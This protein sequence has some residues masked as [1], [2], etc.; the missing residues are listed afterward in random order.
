MRRMWTNVWGTILWLKT[1][2]FETTF[3]I[4]RFVCVKGLERTEE[5]EIAV[6]RDQIQSATHQTCIVVRC[7]QLSRMRNRRECPS[8]CVRMFVWS[9]KGRF[10]RWHT[11]SEERH[12]KWRFQWAQ[13]EGKTLGRKAF[14]SVA[15]TK[16]RAHRTA[17]GT[18]ENKTQRARTYRLEIKHQGIGTSFEVFEAEQGCCRIE[19]NIQLEQRNDIAQWRK[20]EARCSC[21]SFFSVFHKKSIIWPN[22][23]V[24]SN[25]QTLR[26]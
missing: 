21:F 15:Q 5:H 26:K 12:D 6:W 24:L 22:H 13:T 7:W 25:S 17:Q 20:Q 4:A 18:I 2:W 16:R 11:V 10:I 19:N 1:N 9:T 8:T 14:G 3:W 23:S